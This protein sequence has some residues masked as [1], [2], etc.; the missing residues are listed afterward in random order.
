MARGFV[1]ETFVKAIAPEGEIEPFGVEIEN[2]IDLASGEKGTKGRLDEVTIAK[3]GSSPGYGDT[4]ST[5]EGGFIGPGTQALA[6]IFGRK[7]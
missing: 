6:G 3:I 7:S 1:G 2:G 4:A 5:T